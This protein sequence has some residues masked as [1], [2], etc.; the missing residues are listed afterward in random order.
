MN[1]IFNKKLR[2]CIVLLSLLLSLSLQLNVAYSVE[3]KGVD[4][5][6]VLTFL[7][8]AVQLDIAK[9]EV[10]LLTSETNYW[11]WLTG[12]AETTGQY[13]LD[14]TGI[15][16]SKGKCGTSL[17][18]VT[19]TLWDNKL[20]SCALYEKSQGPAIYNDKP[21]IP[22]KDAASNFL[23][24]YQTFTG[25]MQ[26]TQ[27]RSL[28]DEADI[29]SNTTKIV[30]DL[31]LEI[32]TASNNSLFTWSNTLNGVSYSRLH[33]EFKDGYFSEF[34]DDR[35]FYQLGSS[36]LNISQEEAESIALKSVEPYQYSNNT[37]EIANFQ[38]DE[39]NI[40]SYASFLNH[41]NHFVIYPCW[42]VDLPLDDIYAGGYSY[43]E[44]MIWADS[45]EVINVE[46]LGYGY[47]YEEP[48]PTSSE[49]TQI[50]D[51][52]EAPLTLYMS[53]IC[54]AIVIPIAIIII[55]SRKKH[56]LLN[57]ITLT[58]SDI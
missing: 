35:S 43:I 29:N 17:L 8:D 19:F 56:T 52:S 1:M 38:I 37:K 22:P 14:S 16:D 12:T 48:S 27:M 57:P 15:L 26:V 6:D 25:D 39:K 45:G 18:M 11:P 49:I 46:A 13:M 30:N 23:Q 34:G 47:P 40:R 50:G 51:N 4:T 3:V 9:Y 42:I 7:C 36:E 54:L 58:K 10:T 32:F 55:V 41:T 20:V 24:R 28:L 2:V 5:K 33:L 44:V 53:L 31:S 21:A